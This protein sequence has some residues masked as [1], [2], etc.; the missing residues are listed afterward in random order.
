MNLFKRKVVNEVVIKEVKED[1]SITD[2][3]KADVE[4]FVVR[5][6]DEAKKKDEQLT[7]LRN[8][9]EDMTEAFKAANGFKIVADT[10]ERQKDDL[11][12]QLKRKDEKIETLKR[13]IAC[14]EDENKNNED[15]LALKTKLISSC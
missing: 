6:Y 10:L 5:M 8:V 15:D 1:T 11:S 12:R 7:E 4:S 13:S 9:H 14:L 3:I 2:I